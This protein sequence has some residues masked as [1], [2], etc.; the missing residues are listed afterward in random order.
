M[1]IAIYSRGFI[2]EDLANIQ[3]LL[4]E[5]LR[6]EITAVIYEPFYHTLQPHIRFNAEPLTFMRPEDLNSLT[7]DCLVS[8]GGDGTLLDTVC[9]VRDKNIP[10]LG[11]NFGRLGFLASIGKEDIYAAVKALK[12]RTYVVDKRTLLHLD[13]NIPLFWRCALRPQRFYYP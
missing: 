4:D 13:A 9:Y 1:H 7:I 8:L 2:T 6:E 12:Q 3:L 11:I 10:V 5:L